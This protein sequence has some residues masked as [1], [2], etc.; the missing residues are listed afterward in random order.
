MPSVKKYNLFLLVTILLLAC[1]CSEIECPL[2]NLVYLK[3]GIYDVDG[4]VMTFNDTLTVK[5]CSTNVTLL[6]RLSGIKSF[7]VP[8][9]FETGIDTLLLS[10]TDESKRAGVDSLFVSHE[11]SAHFESVDCPMVFFHNISEIQ[12]SEDKKTTFP[13]VVDRVEITAPAVNYDSDE[14]VRVYLRSISD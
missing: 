7:S 1:D 6:N 8:L 10:F 4:N 12:S 5:A 11:S 9:A 3:C 14:N 13:Y 2:D